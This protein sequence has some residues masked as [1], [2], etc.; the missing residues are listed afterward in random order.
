VSVVDV[1]AAFAGAQALPDHARQM[2]A[3]ERCFT[4]RAEAPFPCQ[5]CGG[6]MRGPVCPHCGVE[7][8]AYINPDVALCVA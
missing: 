4:I 8:K 5:G 6:E 1:F 2:A 3:F 7:Q